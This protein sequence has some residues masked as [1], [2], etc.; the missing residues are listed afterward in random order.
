MRTR[1]FDRVIVGLL[2]AIVALMVGSVTRADAGARIIGGI[3]AP[4]GSWPSIAAL[5][6]TNLDLTGDGA[7]TNL[8]AF[9]GGTLIDPEWVL[10][11]AHCLTLP[12]L[13]GAGEIKVA[14]G[15]NNLATD[16][17]QT[18]N[19]ATI[20]RHPG[21]ADN[22]TF[23]DD[24]ALLRLAS[25]VTQSAT[26]APMELVSTLRPELWDDG[27]PAQIAGWGDTSGGG[28]A[29]ATILQ[30][31][32]ITVFAD[33]TCDSLLGAEDPAFLASSMVCAGVLAG[34][35]DA[36]Q[37]DSGGP[38]TVMDGGTRV[39]VG[40]VSWGIGCALPNLPGV[41]SRLDA[42]RSFIFGPLGLNA[43]PPGAPTGVTAVRP[44]GN[45][46]AVLLMWTAGPDG[47]RTIANSVVQVIEGGVPGIRVV[48]PGPA[49]ETTIEG[50]TGGPYT[51]TV[52][53]EHGAGAG[54]ASAPIGITDVSEPVSVSPPTIAGAARRGSTLTSTTG[55]WRFVFGIP[56]ARQ[57]QRCDASGAN[58]QPVPGA[59]GSTF[60]LTDSDVGARIRLGVTATNSV[61]QAHATSQA[62]AVVTDPLPTLSVAPTVSGTARVGSVLVATTG[63]WTNAETTTVV[64]QACDVGG[65][66]CTDIPGATGTSF[67]PLASLVGLRLRVV[68]TASN[69]GGSAQGNSNFS[70]P[71]LAAPAGDPPALPASPTPVAP[72]PP[73]SGSP[74]SPT[75]G[76]PATP[77]LV[78]AKKTVT[79]APNGAVTVRVRITSAP[80]ATLSVRALD[81][82]GTDR[83]LNRMRTRVTGGTTTVLTA[84]RLTTVVGGRGTA[85]ITLTFASNPRAPFR[86][87]KVALVA[88]LDGRRTTVNVAFRAR[89]S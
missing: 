31:A 45:A 13:D 18:R 42:Y 12:Q 70:E 24:L 53:A 20:V 36:C 88:M 73:V 39:L 47:G 84:R 5:V 29:F 2:A 49:T 59:T 64:W 52:R 11:A 43:A 68:V 9:C 54:P 10:T 83:V 25:P 26:I 41:Y 35:V 56:F 79:H 80:G 16:A 1:T 58:C 51:F 76:A 78:V 46:D 3:N 32:S 69:S 23:V 77:Y 72:A 74:G 62:T 44:D 55:N 89:F 14:L 34:G 75:P 40:A 22:D 65:G 30:Q 7:V 50:L 85:D 37:G 15:V 71:V 4:A 17:G 27:S 63:T 19:V 38:L 48:V 57:W 66:G 67:A 33:A 60:T 28:T 61:G 21:F 82:R 81:H 8:D 6:P 87:G 86:A